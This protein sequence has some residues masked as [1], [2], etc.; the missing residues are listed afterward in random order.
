M[1]QNWVM[2]LDNLA[3]CG[4]LDYD[5]PAFLLGQA[6][7]YAGNPTIKEL[8]CTIPGY[9]PHGV[10]M[11]PL[12]SDTYENDGNLVHNP[13]WKKL[14]FAGV[15]IGGSLLIAA[16]LLTLK[17]KI[18][19]PKLPKIKMPKLKMPKFLSGI[20]TKVSNLGSKIAKGVKKPINW[21]KNKFHRP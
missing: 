14:L 10:K 13:K 4:V 9:Q 20:K 16:S 12:C 2:A 18:K 5:A 21:I 17:R 6:P 19:L 11:N 15:A 7:R 3:A 8:P 1:S